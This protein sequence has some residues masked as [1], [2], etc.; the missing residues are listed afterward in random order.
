MKLRYWKYWIACVSTLFLPPYV[1]V[2][3]CGVDFDPD[4][5]RMA[6]FNPLA[7]ATAPQVPFFYSY[8]QLNSEAADQQQQDYQRNCQEWAQ[9][10]GSGVKLADIMAVVY[11]GTPAQFLGAYQEKELMAAYPGNTFV[12]ALLR[13]ENKKLLDYLHLAFRAEFAHFASD[14]PWGLDE[15]V[16][17]RNRSLREIVAAARKQL[18]ATSNAFL[19]QRLTYQILL[20]QRYLGGYREVIDLYEA[21]FAKGP[22]AQSMLGP[23]ATFHAAYAYRQIG[24]RIKAGYLLSR[25]FSGSESKKIRSYFDFDAKSVERI[26]RLANSPAEKAVIITLG[27]LHNPGRSL[28]NLTEIARLDPACPFMPLL[29][30]REINKLEDWLLTPAVTFFPPA[31]GGQPWSEDENTWQPREEASVDPNAQ[32]QVRNQIKDQQY[33][34]DVIRF[35]EEN[36]QRFPAAQA[37]FYRLAL[38]HLYGIDGQERKARNQLA[39]I[40]AAAP[41]VLQVQSKLEEV[42]LLSRG[43]NL[44]SEATKLDLAEALLY[45]Q[46]HAD[47]LA[48]NW[49][50]YPKLL[51]YLA[52]QFQVQGDIISAGLLYNRALLIPTNANLASGYYRSIAFFDRYASRE[53]VDALLSLH[54]RKDKTPFEQVLTAPLTAPEKESPSGYSW[55]EYQDFWQ[56][57]LEPTYP[58]PATEKLLDLKG[59]IAFRENDLTGAAA[60]FNALPKNYWQE[61]YAFGDH[62]QYDP[63]A[64]ANHWPWQGTLL[65]ADKQEIV[66]QAIGVQQQIVSGNNNAQAHYLLGNLYFN[67]SYW[68]NSWMLFS[69]GRSSQELSFYSAYGVEN[70]HFGPNDRRYSNVYYGLERA[71]AQYQQVLRNSP[72]AELAAKAMHMLAYCDE[73]RYRADTKPAI[74]DWDAK[75]PPYFSPFYQEWQQKYRQTQ[76]YATR[77]RECPLLEDYIMENRK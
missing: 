73:L 41:P 53:V 7:G 11:Q 28:T 56:E 18:K 55:D 49:R 69:Y 50:I 33:L 10:M 52:R 61:T 42:V 44:T 67:S 75:I 2:N 1:L 24:D 72:P 19:R 54:Q 60:A 45:L 47:L 35:L 14:D 22:G 59:T 36:Q 46:K 65:P 6:F 32:Y 39:M 23:W 20:Q 29:V 5:Y 48:E 64:D 27:A 74:R 62:L 58:L 26:L 70:F 15:S 71:M 4:A 66:R 30:G 40:S 63:F 57:E 21:N 17:D 12:A 3:S 31:L 8:S 76:T 9:Q 13:P 38:A 77:L 51:L 68:G 43:G 34:H 37:D 25:A 16:T